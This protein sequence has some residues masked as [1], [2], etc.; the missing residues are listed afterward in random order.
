MSGGKA[1]VNMELLPFLSSSA[2][3]DLKFLAIK[4]F[5]GKLSILYPQC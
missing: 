3:H 4:Y 5:V 1:G 2:R